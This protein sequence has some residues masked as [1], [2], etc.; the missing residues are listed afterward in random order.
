M[1]RLFI[2]IGKAIS[3][4]RR[5]GIFSGGKRVLLAFLK[6]FR[7]VGKGDVLIVTGGVGDSARYRVR[8]HAEELNLR[9]IKTSVTIQDNPFLKMYAKKFQIFIFHRVLFVPAVKG[10]VDEI[11]KQGKEIVF[12][13]FYHFFLEI[14]F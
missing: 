14:F 2:Y 10:M 9:G 8:N 12:D 5:D 1:K 7:V 3:V 11:K 4:L 6:M 13:L